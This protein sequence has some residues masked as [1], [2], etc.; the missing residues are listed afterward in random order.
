MLKF[1]ILFSSSGDW[2]NKLL[3]ERLLLFLVQQKEVC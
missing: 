3:I 1:R 2:P